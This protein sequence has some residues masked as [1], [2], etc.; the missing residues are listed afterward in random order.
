M[1]I[2]TLHKYQG[3]VWQ[4]AQQAGASD[5]AATVLMLDWPIWSQPAIDRIIWFGLAIILGLT[6]LCALRRW[7]KPIRAIMI[8]LMLAIAARTL[9]AQPD[10]I[11]TQAVASDQSAYQSAIKAFLSGDYATAIT[12]FE[13]VNRNSSNSSNCV[14]A[15]GGRAVRV[16]ISRT[17]SRA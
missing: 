11:K 17:M 4:H 5:S 2:M 15:L 16:I 9:P 1:V 6:L 13:R 10:L 3:A 7:M 12:K 14:E 8:G